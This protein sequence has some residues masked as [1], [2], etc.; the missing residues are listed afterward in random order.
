M[1]RKRDECCRQYELSVR[2]YKGKQV[3]AVNNILVKR[4]YIHR[5][6][7][8]YCRRQMSQASIYTQARG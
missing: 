3:D 7:N 2:I 6:M 8:E 1:H 5:Q 4:Q